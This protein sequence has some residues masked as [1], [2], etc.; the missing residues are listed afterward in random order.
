MEALVVGL[1]Y[2]QHQPT[3][4]H[5]ISPGVKSSRNTRIAVSAGYA[6]VMLPIQSE[7][8]QLSGLLKQNTQ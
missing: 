6:A 4:N 1:R 8:L 7:L 2:A 5:W 3:A